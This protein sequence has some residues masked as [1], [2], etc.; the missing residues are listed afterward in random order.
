[1]MVCLL[2]YAYCGGVFESEERAGVRAQPGMHRFVGQERLDFRTSSDV[3]T[4]A[5]EACKDMCV[6][7]LRVAGAA[8]MVQLENT[9]TDG[10][11]IQ[12]KA[13]RH[14][15]MSYGSMRKEADRWREDLEVLVTQA[16]Q[17]DAE[18]DAALDSWRGDEL[19]AELARRAACLATLAA[20][21]RRLEARAKAPADEERQQR[22]AA[23]AARQRTGQSVAAKP[24]QRWTRPL[25]T[26]RRCAA[27]PR[28][29]DHA[30]QQQ[31]LGRALS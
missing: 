7:V 30:D 3:R 4:L 23:E 12:G 2:L 9:A 31:R 18:D 6:Q 15:A 17:Q 24:L 19:P 11:K 20:A 21:M 13:S 10:T 16:H 8:G 29:G 5:L 28:A 26:K 25:R 1:M 14:K 27:P 22:A